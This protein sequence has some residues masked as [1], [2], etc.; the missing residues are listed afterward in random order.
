MN[1]INDLLKIELIN[2]DSKEIFTLCGFGAPN[3]GFITRLNLCNKQTG[4]RF[5]ID[6]RNPSFADFQLK[7]SNNKAVK[8]LNEAL[9]I[10]K[11]NEEKY[12]EK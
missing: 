4:E 3:G 8:L 7:D 1:N 9:K 2:I 6:E 5:I 12:E 11:E 10:V